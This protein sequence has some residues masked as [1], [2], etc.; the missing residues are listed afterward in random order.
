MLSLIIASVRHEPDRRCALSPCRASRP[1][2]FT[3]S[4]PFLMGIGLKNGKRRLPSFSIEVEDS[5]RRAGRSTRSA[6]SSSSPPAACSTPVLPPHA[7]RAAAATPTPASALSTKFPFALFRKSRLVEL[8]TEVIVFP[9]SWRSSATPPPPRARV[10][11]L[12]AQGR[13]GRRGEFH[14]LREFRDGDDPRDIHWRSTA[15]AGRTLVREHEE[16]AARRVTI[17]LDNAPARRR[18]VPRRAGQGRPRARH[19]ARRLAGRRLP[20]ARLRGPGGHPRRRRAAVAAGLPPALAP[21]AHARAL[22]DDARRDD[23]LPRRRRRPTPSPSWWC[24]GAARA[25][26][27]SGCIEAEAAAMRFSA[28]HKVDLLPHGRRRLLDARPVA[29]AVAAHRRAHARARPP[30]LLLRALARTPSCARAPGRRRGTRSPL[31][32][33]AWTLLDA[34]RGELLG[35]GMRFLCF[36]L[37]N[38]LWNRTS[39]RDYLHAYV[40]SFLMLVAGAALYERSRLRRLLPRL[41]RLRHLDAD[42]VPSPP[43]D[44]GELPPQALRRRAVRARRGRAHP[45]LA[46]HRR[47]A[48]S[49]CATSHRVSSASSCAPRSSSSSSRASASASSPPIQRRSSLTVGFSDRVDLDAYGR[50][51]DNPQVIM[52]IELPAGAPPEQPL[53]LRGVAFDKYQHGRWTRTVES[54]AR[55]LT[56]WGGY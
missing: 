9:A 51:K 28:I 31:A 39:S 53:H 26:R 21:P 12:E 4:R 30:L 52:R 19:L 43:R 47:L 32:V 33:F 20:R 27:S 25:P 15:E 56:D 24:A 17:F 35:A 46:P 22:A 49:S 7:S 41:R 42:A 10:A 29:R 2:A 44:G 55:Q 34:I 13:K 5:R 37:V 8:T 3:R 45:Q 16:E 23:A 14:G 38:K 11:G 36:L 40:V 54:P 18:G 50:I 1:R 48:R 6:T